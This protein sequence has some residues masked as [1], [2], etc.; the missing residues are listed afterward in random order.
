MKKFLHDHFFKE[1]YSKGKHCLDL[2]SLVLSKKEMALF[3]WRTLKTEVN[4]FIDKSA[5]EKRMDLVVSARL[6]ASRKPAKVL[7]LIEHKSQTDAMLMRQ[8]LM[9]QAGGYDNNRDPILPVL[10][11]QSP[12]KKWQG[13]VDFHGFLNNFEGELKKYFK[14][15]VLNFRPRVLN[16]Q[17]LDIDRKAKGLTTRPTLYIL[18]HIWNL[19]EAKVKKLFTIGCDLSQSEREALIVQAVDYIRQYD[20]NFSW[21][22]IRE[23]EQST[24]KEE[25]RVMAPLLQY[26][27]DEARE[28]GLKQGRQE[29]R[30]EGRQ[31]G[32]Q[33]G[34]SVGIEKGMQSVAVNMLKNHFKLSVIS[35]M[36]GLSTQEIKKLKNGSS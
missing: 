22:V 1:V 12:Y 24:V 13:P 4:S 11:N 3:D 19:N 17:A 32:R 31:E 7:F 25:A 18:K 20:P 28:K 6:K 26:S 27:L 21:K 34:M 30:L 8:F 29:G 33:E 14:H 35:E 2:L 5:R 23:I 36:T 9:Y 15:N 16:I 10:V